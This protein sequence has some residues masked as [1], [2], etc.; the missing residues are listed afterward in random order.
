MREIVFIRRGRWFWPLTAIVILPLLAMAG[1]GGDDDTGNLFGNDSGI[2]SKG[3][4]DHGGDRATLPDTSPD[5]SD[6]SHEAGEP[7]HGTGS[8]I[9][10]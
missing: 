5:R 4:V 8:A 1:C 7:D 9:V 3:S 10:N 6:A 2:D